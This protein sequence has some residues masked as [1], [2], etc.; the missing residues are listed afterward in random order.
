[1]MLDSKVFARN[2]KITSLFVGL[3]PRDIL[4]IKSLKLKF[5][6]GPHNHIRRAACLRS[7]LYMVMVASYL[8]RMNLEMNADFVCDESLLG[9]KGLL[10]FVARML[11]TFP[12]KNYILQLSFLHCF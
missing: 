9:V 8:E 5:I 6:Q 11:S 7:L 2:S 10:A 12:E 1:M 3:N 4:Y